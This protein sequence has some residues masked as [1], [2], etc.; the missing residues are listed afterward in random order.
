MIYKACYLSHCEVVRSQLT[1]ERVSPFFW[2]E[3]DALLLEVCVAQVLEP[4]TLNS[5]W[6]QKGSHGKKWKQAIEDWYLERDTLHLCFGDDFVIRPGMECS[7]LPY[8]D[9]V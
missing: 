1:A 2:W 3:P 8:K 6:L 5:K 9:F 7:S 4:I